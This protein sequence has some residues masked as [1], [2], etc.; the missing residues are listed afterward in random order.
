[1]AAGAKGAAHLGRMVDL[2]ADIRKFPAVR[3]EKDAENYL[4]GAVPDAFPKQFRT[5]ISGTL[6]KNLGFSR[7][8]DVLDGPAGVAYEVKHGR[9]RW[10]SRAQPQLEN[11]LKVLQN[12]VDAIDKV[13]WHFFTSTGN[14]L[15]PNADLLSQIE[16]ARES[17]V[18]ISFVLHVG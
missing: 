18:D 10:F 15:G 1:M 5:P 12:G 3:F 13:E 14:R 8:Y 9:T 17:G 4:R 6:A 2:A 11:D 16:S 7:F